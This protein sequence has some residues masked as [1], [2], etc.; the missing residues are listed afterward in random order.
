[1]TVNITMVYTGN[2]PT[3]AVIRLYE[4]AF[5]TMNLNETIERMFPEVASGKPFNQVYL[6]SIKYEVSIRSIKYLYVQEVTL[7]R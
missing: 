3:V 7:A 1:M 6:R 2:R 4:S 5:V